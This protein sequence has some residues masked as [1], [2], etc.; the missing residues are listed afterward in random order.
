MEQGATALA[1]TG[2][3]RK[4]SEEKGGS[5]R[6]KR[7]RNI[8]PYLLAAR[9]HKAAG[10]REILSRH[11]QKEETRLGRKRGK[12]TQ[13]KKKGGGAPGG[14]KEKKYVGRRQPKEG[15]YENRK[16]R[17]HF[18]EKEFRQQSLKNNK[19]YR[20]CLYFAGKILLRKKPRM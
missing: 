14:K 5:Q 20:Y 2:E 16:E 13:E 12:S 6:G 15:H 19:K 7:G 8:N 3:K 17:G 18:G 10:E 11:Q 4:V 9:E 1:F